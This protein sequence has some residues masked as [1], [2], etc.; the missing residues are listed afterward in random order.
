MSSS[1][2][3]RFGWLAEQRLPASDLLAA[4]RQVEQLGYDSVWL[5]DHLADERGG[6]LLDP[7]TTLG[8]LLTSVPRIVAGTLVASNSLRAPLLTA[9]MART[10][11]D[12]APGRFV[13]GLGAGGSRDEHLRVGVEYAAFHRRVDDLRR[14]CQLIRRVIASGSP[15]N[16]TERPV[17]SAE[18]SV[19]LV[20]GGLSPA[21]LELAAMLADGWAVWGSPSELS[22]QGAMLSRFASAAGRDPL[23]VQ[24]SAIVMLLPDHLPEREGSSW[25]AELRGDEDTVGERLGKYV[26]A[27]VGEVV[28][29]DYGVAPDARQEA[30]EW[31]AAAMEQFRRGTTQA[32]TS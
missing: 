19:P 4:V 16:Q 12:L 30:L 14:S 21:I 5:S 29:C 18:Q 31:F 7:W 32:S 9:Q 25:P 10:L 22:R 28:V 1:V 20:L 13:L 15:W 3:L 23:D 8:A 6:W 2:A 26:E 17:P 24:R 27:G 11:A